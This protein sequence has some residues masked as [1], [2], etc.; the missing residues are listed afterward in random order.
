MTAFACCLH[1]LSAA[2]LHVLLLCHHHHLLVIEQLRSSKYRAFAAAA[3]AHHADAVP[4]TLPWTVAWLLP[5]PVGGDGVCAALL[6]ATTVTRR[7]V[8]RQPRLARLSLSQSHSRPLCHHRQRH[9]CRRRHCVAA[10][11]WHD[12]WLLLLVHPLAA[13]V[14]SIAAMVDAS[15]AAW[16]ELAAASVARCPLA[17]SATG[18][19]PS[20]RRC[21]PSLPVLSAC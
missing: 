19:H 9:Q 15:S 16:A 17:Q 2:P 7:M 3:L 14:W 20:W 8:T 11:V 12:A 10:G 1:E 4:L 13:A 5:L 18:C 6:A 21:R